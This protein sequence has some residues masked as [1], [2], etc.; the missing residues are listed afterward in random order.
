MNMMKILMYKRTCSCIFGD[1]SKVSRFIDN[2]MSKTRS[3]SCHVSTAYSINMKLKWTSCYKN[4]RSWLNCGSVMHF[5]TD[6]ITYTSLWYTSELM[7]YK[8]YFYILLLI[9][10][11]VYTKSV[12]FANIYYKFWQVNEISDDILLTCIQFTINCV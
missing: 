12:S 7:L 5:Y 4:N 8:S 2:S 3:I 10:S 11:F 9:S 1:N 6:T